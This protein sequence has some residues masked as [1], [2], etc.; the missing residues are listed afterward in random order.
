MQ[1]KKVSEDEEEDYEL[2]YGEMY[3][4]QCYIRDNYRIKQKFEE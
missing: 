4:I 3:D 1:Q 2:S